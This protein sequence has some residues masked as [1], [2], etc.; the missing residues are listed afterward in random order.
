MKRP[1]QIARSV[2]GSAASL[3]QAGGAK[4]VPQR[5]VAG[6]VSWVIAIMIALTV[7]AAAGGIAL[8]NLADRARGDL[9][10]AITVQVVEADARVKAAQ[11]ET[12]SALL[13][14]DPAVAS[15]RV[16]PEEE[17]G[18]LLEPWLGDVAK[19]D[20]I[21]IPALVDVQL[22]RD[23]DVAEVA[24]LQA[25]VEEAVPTAQVDAQSDW[26]KPV[27]SALS[28]LQYLAYALIA[29][30]ALTGTAAVWLAS[31]S[32]FTSHRETV[33]IV[34]L[35]GGTDQQ[36]ARIFQRSVAIDALLGGIAGLALGAIAI[37]L[38]GSQFAALDSGLV[39]GGGFSTGD[40]LVIG[41][42]PLV[43]LVLA[44]VTARFTVL[45]A[46]KRML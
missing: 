14:R 23:A 15:L 1:P 28:S 46:L 4:L 36:I 34:H 38:I 7:V 40:W 11:V 8:N 9:S 3:S 10:G 19:G 43:G 17:L 33:E 45:S 25:L 29:L 42:I 44:I 12:V 37:F 35:L 24:R 2:L 32:A 31:R 18:N 20:A 13:V 21:P 27:Y 6:P 16:V 5:R 41:A 30:L 26:L 39:S 22:R